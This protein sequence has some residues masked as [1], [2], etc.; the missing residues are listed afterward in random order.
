MHGGAD[1]ACAIGCDVTAGWDF[2]GWGAG[3]FTLA[4]DDGDVADGDDGCEDVATAGG[5]DVADGV[6]D[7]A[8]D[9][10]VPGTEELAVGDL[11]QWIPFPS[12]S[13]FSSPDLSC[14]FSLYVN[15]KI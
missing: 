14:S 1:G 12:S 7:F 5:D 3:D 11:L 6:G 10:I 15:K 13:S 4:A 2:G 8:T 9:F